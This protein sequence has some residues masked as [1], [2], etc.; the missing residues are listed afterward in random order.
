M[1]PDELYPQTHLNQLKKELEDAHK[2]V[3]EQ[4]EDY[5][6]L[7]DSD[8]DTDK[9]EA[10]ATDTLLDN[11]QLDLST[12]TSLIA[13]LNVK[14]KAENEPSQ[15]T[16]KRSNE[17]SATKLQRFV[18]PKFSGDTR[19]FPAFITHYKKHVETQYGKDP[20]TLMQCL[21]G[22]AEKHVRPVEE[23]YDEMM[24]RLQTKYGSDEKQVDVILKDLKNLKR[25]PDGDHKAL[26]KMIETVEN[27]WLDLKRMKLES[28]MD[29]TSML[30]AIEKL[31]P[32]VQKREWTL[33]K[34]SYSSLSPSNV[35]RGPSKFQ[36]L[37]TFLTKEKSAIEYMSDDLRNEKPHHKGKINVADV[38]ETN[39]EDAPEKEN[40]TKLVINLF[41]KQ[42]ESNRQLMEIIANAIAVKDNPTSNN[43][44]PSYPSLVIHRCWIHKSNGHDITECNTFITMKSS[45][46]VDSVK[47]NRICFYCLQVGHAARQ[48]LNKKPC[49][50]VT[51]GVSCK[52]S[53]HQLLHTAHVEG[54]IYHS[55]GYV[56]NSSNIGRST[57]VLLMISA[58]QCK[59]INLG[60]L[61]DSGANVTLITHRA[62]NQLNLVGIDVFI[63][64]TK[65]GNE[66]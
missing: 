30:S 59:G 45:D 63:T 48:C 1:K 62:A 52:G 16:E 26:H 65:V 64:I 20:F 14:S 12:V 19:A 15:K 58:V 56:V 6:D 29:T 44:N 24:N 3:E 21:S 8:D 55:R 34:P 33:L 40:E 18:P 53:H 5:R 49:G 27:C 2:E 35:E 61:W 4:A 37:L 25:V 31:L 36:N 28:E 42:M 38:E 43:N 22:E 39:E 51:N 32:E 17:S 46:K 47:K 7:L 54:L 60:T 41:E 57:T 11:L 13:K 10:Q 9:P 23:D 50:Q 66:K